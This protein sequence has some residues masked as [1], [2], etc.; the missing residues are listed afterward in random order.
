[1]KTLNEGLTMRVLKVLLVA[2]LLAAPMMSAAGPNDIPGSAEWYLHVDLKQM[3]S[4]EAGKPVYE[5][6]RDEA[7]NDV[8]NDVGVDIDREIDSVTAFSIT[9][10]GPVVVIAGDFSSETKDKIMAIIAAEGD[11]SPLKA[12]GRKYYRL[13]DGE[14]NID[15]ESADVNITLDSLDDGGWISLDVKDKILI[16]GGEEQMKSLLANKGRVPGPGSGKGALLVLTAE[17]TLLQAGMNTASLGGGGDDDL[18]SKILRNTEQVAFLLA[19]VRDKLAIEAELI[20]SEPEMAESLASVARGLIS[21]V[22]FD[23]SMDAEAVAV[24]QSTRIEAKGNSLNLSLAVD[25]NLVVRTIG[26]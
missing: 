1:M 3:K 16:T 26:N 9:G 4:E 11:L 7:F 18:D 17:K 23:D 24:L 5:W 6:L 15:Y 2:V 8:K 14:G 12:S 20:T 25:P 13:G 21:L 10:Q 22:S 19:V